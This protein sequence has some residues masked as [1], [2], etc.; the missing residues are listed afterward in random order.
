M[1]DIPTGL[2]PPPEG[3]AEWLADLKKTVSKTPNPDDR[4]Y[5]LCKGYKIKPLHGK[6]LWQP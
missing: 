3:Y 5:F 4:F 1:S 2:I 6:T